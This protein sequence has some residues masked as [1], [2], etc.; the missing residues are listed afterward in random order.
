V[1][2]SKEQIDGSAAD[3]SQATRSRVAGEK[4]PSNWEGP[5]VVSRTTRPFDSVVS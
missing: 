1:A 3:L 5:G 4:R 2:L